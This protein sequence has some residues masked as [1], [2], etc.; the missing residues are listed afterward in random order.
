MGPCEE[1]LSHFLGSHPYGEVFVLVDENTEACC[2]PRLSG[3]GELAKAVILR[4]QAG[5]TFKNLDTCSGIWRQLLDAGAGRRGLLIN[6]G[7]GVIGDMGGFC[8]ATYKRGMDFVQVP[9]TLLSQVDASIGGKL[10]VDF[11]EVKNS[12]GVFANPRAVFIDP[13]FLDTLSFREV[14]SGYAEIVKHALIADAGLW[15]ALKTKQELAALSW[16]ELI[17][18]SLQIKKRIVV[19]DPFEKGLRKTLNFGHTIGHAIEAVSLQ[20]AGPLLHGE[21]IAAGMICEAWLSFSA[22]LLDRLDLEAISTYLIQ[23][24]QPQ[25]LSASNYPAYLQLMRNDKKNEAD[26]INFTFIGPPGTAHVNQK[27]GEA[28]IRASFAYL[29]GRLGDQGLG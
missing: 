20:A 2:L 17:P 9:T 14:R 12:I 29:N 27:A 26:E 7:G 11:H 5:E 6:L 1:A 16:I 21:A 18:P 13:G 24:Y 3:V 23:V 10:G 28:E 19:A 8:A 22:G 15:N 25:P 4:I